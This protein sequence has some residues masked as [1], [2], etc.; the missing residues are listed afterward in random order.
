MG[1]IHQDIYLHSGGESILID[2]NMLL[3]RLMN[4]L[5]SSHS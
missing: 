3:H 4:L 5:L 2:K 1:I